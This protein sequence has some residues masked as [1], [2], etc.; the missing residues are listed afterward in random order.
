MLWSDVTDKNI[1]KMKHLDTNMDRL[2]ELNN[3][4]MMMKHEHQ[5]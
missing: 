1:N 4:Q 5:K 3:Q 2:V